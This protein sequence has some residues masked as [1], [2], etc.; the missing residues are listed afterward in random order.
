MLPAGQPDVAAELQ[1]SVYSAIL[2]IRSAWRRRTGG[3][4]RCLCGFLR[5]ARTGLVL[6]ARRAGVV[7]GTLGRIRQDLVSSVQLPQHVVGLKPLGRLLSTIESVG[8][9]NPSS[10]QVCLANILT[11]CRFRN[12]EQ[13]VQAYRHRTTPLPRDRL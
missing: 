6:C 2:R 1:E 13:I 5:L 4:R 11:I 9:D 3:F 7:V 12:T 8:V 10:N